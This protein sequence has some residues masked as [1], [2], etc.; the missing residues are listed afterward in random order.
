M[1]I[2]IILNGKEE[3]IIKNVSVLGLLEIKKVKPEA[4]AVEVNG[5]ILKRN[6]FSTVIIKDAD[7][8]EIVFFM[9]GG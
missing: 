7:K 5:K 6:E 1:E 4:V 3:K 2:S 9:G 8:V